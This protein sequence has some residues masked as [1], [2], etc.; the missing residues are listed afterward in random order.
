MNGHGQSESDRKLPDKPRKRRRR[1]W[2][3]FTAGIILLC[4]LAAGWYA[5][6]GE[7]DSVL[8]PRRLSPSYRQWIGMTREFDRCIDPAVSEPARTI[9]IDLMVLSW[10][11][12]GC[13]H[14]RRTH[15]RANSERRL[16]GSEALLSSL[17]ADEAVPLETRVTLTYWER[18]SDPRK[19]QIAK[20]QAEVQ[21]EWEHLRTLA[22]QDTSL[23]ARYLLVFAEPQPDATRTMTR[24]RDEEHARN[25]YEQ[26]ALL[27]KAAER[28]PANGWYPYLEVSAWNLVSDYEGSPSM[29][30][31]EKAEVAKSEL[32]KAL[33]R[34]A[35]SDY[36][37]RELEPPLVE[38]P[39]TEDFP[40]W[41]F[42]LRAGA[43]FVFHAYVHIDTGLYYP[44]EGPWPEQLLPVIRFDRKLMDAVEPPLNA[45]YQGIPRSIADLARDRLHRTLRDF[46]EIMSEMEKSAEA[47]ERGDMGEFMWREPRRGLSP[48]YD[49]N[50]WH[51]CTKLARKPGNLL[52]PEEVDQFLSML[53]AKPDYAS[54]EAYEK[55]L[56]F[57]TLMDAPVLPPVAYAQCVEWL[58]ETVEAMSVE[59][60]EGM[61]EDYTE[62]RNSL[63]AALTRIDASVQQ[64]RPSLVAAQENW[65]SQ[66]G[67]STHYYIEL[68][69]LKPSVS[70]RMDRLVEWAKRN[71]PWAGE[72]LEK[73]SWLW[74][75][76]QPGADISADGARSLL[77]KLMELAEAGGGKMSKRVAPIVA[78]LE[79]ALDAKAVRHSAIL[80]PMD[81]ETPKL[82][83]AR[84]AEQDEIVPKLDALLA[85]MAGHCPMYRE[86][87]GSKLNDCLALMVRAHQDRGRQDWILFWRGVK[88]LEP[89]LADMSENGIQGTGEAGRMAVKHLQ[90]CVD[91]I[92]QRRTRYVHVVEHENGS[93][94]LTLRQVEGEDPATLSDE[95]V[96]ILRELV[97]V[98][99]RGSEGDCKALA[100]DR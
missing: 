62:E 9:L 29:G 35:A 53:S 16:Q 27:R 49:R 66:K 55:L 70:S 60:Y 97:E 32:V 19:E 75:P 43:G 77:H 13:G 24:V 74:H 26:A 69:G 42:P 89:L 51:L 64:R 61:G 88:N 21:P 39:I 85:V 93:P 92:N 67:S 28:D 44:R 58:K 96:P 11:Q 12:P 68:D 80:K 6:W 91:D 2:W 14:M 41:S 82:R 59:P 99:A 30:I 81:C 98:V 79:Q 94:R 87:A 20:M 31:P 56:H 22:E 86:D 4:L 7:S 71:E 76:S 57:R 37:R 95:V 84:I 3:Y 100:N 54:R 52:L 36:V 15:V 38:A 18:K 10:I 8:N 33:N 65:R 25:L 40:R 73:V 5:L 63:L 17:I 34:V 47:V 72:E 78:R 50:L 83:Q 1:P 46:A 45:D 48:E 23:P 90:D